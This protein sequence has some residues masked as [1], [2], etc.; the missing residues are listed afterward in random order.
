ML[1]FASAAV[2]LGLLS[3]C[4][5]YDGPVRAHVPARVAYVEP[6]GVIPGPGYVW[7]YHDGYGWGWHHPAY[8]WYGRRFY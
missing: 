5:I 8:G 7:Q 1:R 4:V 2:C 3:G 6:V